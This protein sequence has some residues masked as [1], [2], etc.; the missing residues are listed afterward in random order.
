M[1]MRMVAAIAK[2]GGYDVRSD[3]V[4]TLI[5]MCLTGTAISDVVKRAGIQ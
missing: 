3:P 4:Q 1:Q 5:F 2:I